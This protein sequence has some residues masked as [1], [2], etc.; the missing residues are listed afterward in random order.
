[1]PRGWGMV[2]TRRS[3]PGPVWNQTLV[4]VRPPV[5]AGAPAAPATETSAMS[6]STQVIRRLLIHPLR[7]RASLRSLRSRWRPLDA[8]EVRVL[9]MR[10]ILQPV[11]DGA[12]DPDVRQPDQGELQAQIAVS[13]H[14]DDS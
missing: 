7:R 8:L 3:G 14:S 10:R 2:T 13:K 5:G 11:P 12:I 1:M 9:V 6:A 4:F